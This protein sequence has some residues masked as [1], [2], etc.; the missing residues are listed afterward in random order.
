MPPVAPVE[1]AA[2]KPDQS[3]VVLLPGARFFVRR[4]SLATGSDITAQV[5]LALEAMAPF[6]LEQLYY[7]CIVDSE[8]RHALVYASYRRNFT[9]EEQ[10]AWAEAQVVLPDFAVWAVA[11]CSNPPEVLQWSDGQDHI[12][13]SWDGASPLPAAIWHQADPATA[14]AEIRRRTGTPARPGRSVHG[15]AT[16]RVTKEGL[17]L[18]CD[19]FSGTLTKE[20]FVAADVRD[21][22]VLALHLRTAARNRT[23]L[24]IFLG[25]AIGLAA[26]LVLELAVA[27]GGLLLRK[28]KQALA[29]RA[30]E[31]ARIESAQNLATRLEKL[32][33][34]QLKPFEMLAAINVPR[35]A[36]VAFV[37]VSTSG[38]LQLEVEAQTTSPG[39]MRNYE[40]AL[41]KIDGIE[42]VELRDPRMRGGQTTFSL[43][44]T[45]KAGWLE[46][47]GGA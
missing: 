21:K 32:S 5:E 17:S 7:G 20:A 33:A 3:G 42:Q 41:R 37:R 4:V 6:P 27:G 11:G 36:S 29:A 35:P 39:D 19:T 8:Q 14:D 16:A 2:A 1:I 23:V 15:S 26:C 44:V 47:G 24:R 10:A 28:Q 22:E 40:A 25:T 30:P 46:S 12:V 13:V 31:I 45:F 9:A 34:G 38:P 18:H 43:A